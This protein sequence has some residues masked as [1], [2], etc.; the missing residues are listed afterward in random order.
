LTNSSAYNITIAPPSGGTL[1][2]GT[3][4]ISSSSSYT[5]APGASMMYTTVA[6]NTI[7]AV[8]LG[9]QAGP[10]G[11]QGSQGAQGAQGSTSQI[12]LQ[13]IN[14]APT[15]GGLA[16]IGET[17][18]RWAA[19]NVLTLGSSVL[20]TTA[21]YLTAGQVVKNITFT[22]Y[23]TAGASVTGTWAGLFTNASS[24]LTLVAATAQQGLSSLAANTVFTWPIATIASG[25]SS[26]Y[27]VPS[28]GLYYVGI[29]VTASTMPVIGAALSLV[30]VGNLLPVPSFTLTGSTNP[31]SIGTTY[32]GAGSAYTP[33]YILS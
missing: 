2:V 1:Y 27:T 21:I 5:L 28:S 15:I 17:I 30:P 14:L 16:I 10:Q 18:P 22:T 29:C 8:Q 31:P 20:R 32:A 11:A 12:A 26:T 4:A 24:T 3:T 13:E 25:S 33:Y 9:G 6:A 19:T 23:S 7:Y